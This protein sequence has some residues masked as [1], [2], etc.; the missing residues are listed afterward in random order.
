MTYKELL[1]QEHP[2]RVGEKY[3]GG[4]WGCPYT[5][6]YESLENSA[7]VCL[8][9]KGDCE[10]CWDREIPETEGTEKM[11]ITYDEIPAGY[12]RRCKKKRTGIRC[13]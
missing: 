4:C 13:N 1:A 11:K 8:K 3:A 10:A 9:L 2:D 5:Y 6:G 7:R 12:S